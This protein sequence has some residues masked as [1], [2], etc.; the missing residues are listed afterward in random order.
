[1]QGVTHCMFARAKTEGSTSGRLSG[2]S[3]NAEPP[4]QSP[5]LISIDFSSSLFSGAA[6]KIYKEAG[7][8]SD[9]LFVF[10]PS[11]TYPNLNLSN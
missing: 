7:A 5:T 9:L 11:A 6:G 3:D 4:S 1:M 8:P 10:L 2:A